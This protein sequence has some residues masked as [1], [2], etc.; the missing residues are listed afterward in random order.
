VDQPIDDQ[1]S[2]VA[3]RENSTAEVSPMVDERIRISPGIKCQS[4]FI[5]VVTLTFFCV[6]LAAR[7]RCVLARNSPSSVSRD[8][9][10]ASHRNIRIYPSPR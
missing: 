9:V 1:C 10:N 2:D 6:G 7:R 5:A 3:K 8:L 4:I